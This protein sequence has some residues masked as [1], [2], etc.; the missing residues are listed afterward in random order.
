VDIFQKEI[1]GREARVYV[2]YFRLEENSRFKFLGGLSVLEF[3]IINNAHRIMGK[4]FRETRRGTL[5]ENLR[6]RRK[7]PA[8]RVYIRHRIQVLYRECR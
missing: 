4:R 8:S 7:R 3:V 2:A 6:Y 5:P 1:I